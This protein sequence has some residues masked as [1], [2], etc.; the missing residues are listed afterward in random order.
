MSV[1]VNQKYD[2]DLICWMSGES[3][4]HEGVDIL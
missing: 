1:A 3:F 2:I 4:N